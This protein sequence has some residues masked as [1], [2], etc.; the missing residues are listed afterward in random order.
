MLFSQRKGFTPVKKQI[1]IESIDEDLRRLYNFLLSHP[2][3]VRCFLIL[4]SEAKAPTRFVLNGKSK[5]GTHEIPNCDGCFHVRRTV[6]AAASF[7]NKKSAHYVCLI[8]VF[9]ERPKKLPKI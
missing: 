7:S 9:T 2:G 1:Q 4:I 6:K 8:E 3:N 5:L